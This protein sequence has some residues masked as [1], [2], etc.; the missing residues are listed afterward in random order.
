MISS[1]LFRNRWPA[2]K[3]TTSIASV[4][5][6]ELSDEYGKLRGNP[7][8]RSKPY[9]VGDHNG[10]TLK[11]PSN[12]RGI[13]YEPR[14]AMALW[15]LN[16][17]WPRLGGGQQ[18]LLDYQVPLKAADTDYGIGKIDLL[19]VTDR[20]RLVVVELKFPRNG[21]RGDS[22]MHAL[23]EGLRYAAIVEG[24]SARI[25]KEVEIRFRCKV[26]QETPPIVQLLGTYCWWSAWFDS[27]LRCRAAGDW[28]REFACLALRI[29][30][31]TGVTV[32]CVATDT[33]FRE[34][35]AGLLE[36]RPTLDLAPTL[37]AVRLDP[38]GFCQL[39]SA[40]SRA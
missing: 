8:R 2:K 33:N 23:M 38:P 5:P 35:E 3:L 20:G 17:T 26:D 25:A 36:E 24:C 27:D 12:A 32:E 1:Y 19:A 4:D 22:P 30:K 13:Q 14:Y 9:L 6:G 7:P 29:G 31:E 18:R 40:E 15:N 39:P 16:W 10:T 28:N 37:Y 11:R 34:V 21:H